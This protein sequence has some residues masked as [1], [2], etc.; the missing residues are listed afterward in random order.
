MRNELRQKYLSNSRYERYLNATQYN[1]NRAKRLYHANIRLAQSIHPILTQFEVVLRNGLNVQLSNYFNDD[2]WIITQKNGFMNN[3]SLRRS[4]FYLK[5]S[6]EGTENE[7][8]RRNIPITDGKIIAD[9]NFGFWISFFLRHHYSLIG[10]QPIRIFPNKPSVEDRASIYS[11]L[12]EI[13]D[14]RNRINH[15]EPICFLGSRIDCSEI[16][17]IR[18]KVYDLLDWIEPELVP[19]FETIDNVQSKV[20]NVLRI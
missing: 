11:K 17:N 4:N 8:R 12:K 7:L 20:D 15:C 14:F 9:Q 6:I 13:K 16:L 10:G 19:F 5:R 1:A 3:N 18:T 2:N